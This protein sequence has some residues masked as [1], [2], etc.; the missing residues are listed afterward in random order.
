MCPNYWIY[1]VHNWA[2]CLHTDKYGKKK[3]KCIY[4]EVILILPK[5]SNIL[6]DPTSLSLSLRLCLSLPFSS[7]T[8]AHLKDIHLSSSALQILLLC[9]VRSFC[10]LMQYSAT[11]SL[12]SYGMFLC[13]FEWFL[14][15][16][17][18]TNPIFA[19]MFNVLALF[20]QKSPAQN[21]HLVNLNI[22]ILP[23]LGSVL[24]MVPILPKWHLD[25]LLKC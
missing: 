13:S 3:K 14:S 1:W 8:P 23:H 25:T 9:L 10:L 17:L 6:I 11:P 4:T 24:V 22:S 2:K 15:L 16:L 12:T 5:P 7:E 18:A 20:W 21:H 19:G